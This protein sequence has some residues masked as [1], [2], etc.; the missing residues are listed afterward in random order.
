[1]GLFSSTSKTAGKNKKNTKKKSPL[2][3]PKTAQD[4][5]PYMGVY[6]NGIIQ[7]DENSYSKAYVIPDM[8]FLLKIQKSR[9]KHLATLWNFWVHLDQKYI[10]SR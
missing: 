7:V 1:M 2:E 5:I 3:V 6:E 10:F 4:S 9:R 8:N